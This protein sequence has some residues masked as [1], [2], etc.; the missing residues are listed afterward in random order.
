[1]HYCLE[2]LLLRIW[3]VAILKIQCGEVQII[4]STIVL[5]DTIF[6]KTMDTTCQL[7]YEVLEQILLSIISMA[8]KLPKELY[9]Q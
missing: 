6:I 3:K 4:T 2:S 9:K 8:N 7:E 5:W 1:L